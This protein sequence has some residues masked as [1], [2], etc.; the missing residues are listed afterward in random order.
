MIK[1]PDNGKGEESV[2][3]QKPQ[4]RLWFVLRKALLHMWFSVEL[5]VALIL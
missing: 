5:G 4:S 1:L 3:V 2:I